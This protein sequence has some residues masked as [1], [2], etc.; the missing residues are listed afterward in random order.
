VD[1]YG[2]WKRSIRWNRTALPALLCVWQDI[3]ARVHE[4]NISRSES[5]ATE[6]ARQV[7]LALAVRTAM[8]EKPPASIS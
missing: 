7:V 6:H 8:D 2:Y 4:N 5:S 3:E 1:L